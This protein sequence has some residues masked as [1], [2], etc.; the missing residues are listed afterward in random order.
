MIDLDVTL[1]RASFALSARFVSDAQ[2]TALFG[3]SGSGKS[4]LVSLIAGL[5]APDQGR[6]AV[7]GDTLVDTAVRRRLPPWHRR[8]GLVFQDAQLF[9]HLTVAEN[10]AYGARYAP[11]DAKGI[12]R[13]TVLDTLG[14]GHSPRPPARDAVGRR[15]SARRHRPGA[16][17][18][19]AH[20]LDGRAARLA[21]RRP[22]G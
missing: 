10:L 22:Q 18:A 2:I 3:P 9:P 6:I 17:V 12:A 11:R 13:D 8:I 19:A 1:K 4:T 15:A 7:A 14:I 20:P 5:V 16:P 21:R